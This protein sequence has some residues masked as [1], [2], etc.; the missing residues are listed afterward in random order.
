VR[1]AQTG[2]YPVHTCTVQGGKFLP[3]PAVGPLRDREQRPE[4]VYCTVINIGIGVTSR[5]VDQHVIDSGLSNQARPG[6]PPL[7]RCPWGTI[8]FLIAFL[9]VALPTFSFFSHSSF[10]PS[11]GSPQTLPP[12]SVYQGKKVPLSFTSQPV[13][14]DSRMEFR[15]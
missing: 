13:Y 15:L 1:K 14:F 7:P 4:R 11:V 8:S 9:S 10:S 5:D 12:D 2:T 6:L 3:L